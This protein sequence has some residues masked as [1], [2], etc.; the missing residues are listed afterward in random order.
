MAD[1]TCT[2]GSNDTRHDQTR[3]KR[4]RQIDTLRYA[5][6]FTGAEERNA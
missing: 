2:T 6:A 1:G 3:E 5:L 4:A